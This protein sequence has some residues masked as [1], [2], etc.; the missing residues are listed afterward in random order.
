MPFHNLL[1][2]LVCLGLATIPFTSNAETSPIIE[3]K[4]IS[5]LWVNPGFYSFHFQ[6]DKGLNGNNFGPGIEYRYSTTSSVTVGSFD[7]S[8]NQNSHFAGWYWQ[9][10]GL[11]PARLGMVVGVL[12]GYPKM[13]DGG[14][15]PAVIP[16]VSM[17]YKMVGTNI[18][19]IP[20]YKDRL[21]GAI[22]VQVKLKV[23]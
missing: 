12:D 23:Y 13:K 8:D 16:A 7:N 15:F 17:E 2:I 6:R 9:P 4:P 18:L 21:Y 10:I 22:S 3:S 19:I 20:G 11:G 1:K 5:E 14:W